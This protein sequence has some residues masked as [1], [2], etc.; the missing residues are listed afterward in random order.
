MRS[1]NFL[2]AIAH[3]GAVAVALCAATPALAGTT[4]DN[5][6]GL[7]LQNFLTSSAVEE[8]AESFLESDDQPGLEILG[9]ERDIKFDHTGWLCFRVNDSHLHNHRYLA[10]RLV[11][12][13]SVFSENSAD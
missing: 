6:N 9:G 3:V 2:R 1:K 5:F 12:G 7:L 10:V 8:L 4:I 11:R 13:F